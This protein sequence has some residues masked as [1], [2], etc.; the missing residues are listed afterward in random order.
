MSTY[1]HIVTTFLNRYDILFA[2]DKSD[3]G[4]G[5]GRRRRFLDF[6]DFASPQRL[7]RVGNRTSRFRCVFGSTNGYRVQKNWASF[8]YVRLG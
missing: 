8:S 6:M 1:Q 5:S 4:V 2:V 7:K 3:A